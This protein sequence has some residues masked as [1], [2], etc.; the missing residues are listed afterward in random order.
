M[1][2]N[3]ESEINDLVIVSSDYRTC[4]SSSCSI[5]LFTLEYFYAQIVLNLG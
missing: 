1:T 4:V 3:A 2:M 5:L